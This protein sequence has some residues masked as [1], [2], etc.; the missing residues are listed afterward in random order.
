[1]SAH[2]SALRTAFEVLPACA[3]MEARRD[4]LENALHTSLTLAR[5][6]RRDGYLERASGYR[7]L[8]RGLAV[9]SPADVDMATAAA[10]HAAVSV[11]GR[12]AADRHVDRL[13]REV[14]L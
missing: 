12:P 6:S 2:E 13:L 11:S 10:L 1:M 5:E 8:A 3:G 7:R 4:L 14:G 9:L